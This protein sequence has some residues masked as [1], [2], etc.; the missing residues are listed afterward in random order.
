[1]EMALAQVSQSNK[2]LMIFTAFQVCREHV[3]HN[4]FHSALLLLLKAKKHHVEKLSRTRT[5][6][7]TFFLN[8]CSHFPETIHIFYENI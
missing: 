5:I 7:F 3:L 1:M 6:Y 8:M 2:A 4:F